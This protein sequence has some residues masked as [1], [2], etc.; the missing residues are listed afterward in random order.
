MT[1]KIADL[2]IHSFYSDGTMSPREILIEA[3]KQDVG[4]LAIT[5]HNILE[6]TVE[7]ILI[8]SVL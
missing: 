8:L 5:D 2:H 1:D 3:F 6:G 7:L 4:L